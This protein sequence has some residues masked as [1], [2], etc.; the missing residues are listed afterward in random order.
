LRVYG[1][2]FA[3]AQE[4]LTER[5]DN[6]RRGSAQRPAK[7]DVVEL[8]RVSRSAKSKDSIAH[9]ELIEMWA[10][11]DESERSGTMLLS[12]VLILPADMPAARA[13]LS[14]LLL[15]GQRSLHTSDE[16]ARRRRLILDA[17]GLTAGLSAAVWRYRRPPRVDREVAANR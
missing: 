9:D 10:F 1:H 4:E 8:V 7:K 3:G 2:L 16:S 17:V 13:R 5:L 15:P 14:G 12:V 11:S 6:L